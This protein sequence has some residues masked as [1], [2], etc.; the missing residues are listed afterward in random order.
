MIESSVKKVSVIVPNYNYEDYLVERLDSILNQKYPIYELIFLDDCS[1]DNSI[2]VAKEYF[3][4]HPEINARIVANTKNTGSPFKQ[5]HKGFELAKGDYIW[6]AE[7]DDTCSPDFLK[8]V[9]VGFDDPEVVISYAESN[10]IDENGTLLAS[11]CRDWMLA[12]ST[13]HWNNNYCISGEEEIKAGL[14]IMNTI[15]NVSAVVFKQNKEIPSILEKSY[16]YKISGD[17]VFYANLLKNGK[18]YYCADSL[19]YFRKHTGSLSTDVKKFIE[20]DE[21]LTIQKI[22]R[23]EWQLNSYDIHRQS[24]RYEG[25]LKEL[26]QKD[27]KILKEKTAKNIAWLVPTPIKGSG[28]IRTIFDNA[29]YLVHRGYKVDVYVDEDYINTPESMTHIIEEYYGKCDCRIF[30]GISMRQ[31]YDLIFT[32]FSLQA[33]FINYID[34]PHKASF[35]QDFEP[36][37]EPRGELYLRAENSYRYGLKGI[38]IGRWLANKIHHEYHMDMNCFNFCADTSIYK[39][40]HTEKEDAVCFIFQPQKPRRCSQ[41]GL[42]ALRIVEKL[43]PNT[44]IYLYGSDEK[45]ELQDNEQNLKLITPEECNELYNKCRVGLCLSSSNPSRIPFEMMASGLPVVDLYLENNLYDMPDSS[46]L[47]AEPTPEAIATAII[48]IL[49]DKKLQ[50]KMSKSGIEY[51]SNYPIEKGYEQFGEIVDNILN[52]E[53]ASGSTNI[54][55]VYRSAPIK[56]SKEVKDIARLFH[57]SAPVAPTGR[58]VRK[59]V[60]TK[61]RVKSKYTKAVKKVFRICD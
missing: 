53:K 8:K 24:Y 22:I 42:A 39:P 57:D 55:M 25:S 50:Q 37:F 35:I 36:W 3:A 59:L 15:P 60:K 47:L 21:V 43:R 45:A 18:I 16:A 32:T 26:S 20:I 13:T 52:G 48:K 31:P 14:C 27:Q 11:S 34:A 1:T 46:I 58:L 44:K 30:I 56:P 33:N 23:D 28:G 7:A 49:D 2:K 61:K 19:N 4:N 10:R 38:S 17:W 5:W 6:V 54:K 9:M 41:T 12:A 40:L 51:M 29:N